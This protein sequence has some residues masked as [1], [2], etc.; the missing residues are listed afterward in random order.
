M[1]WSRVANER[2]NVLLFTI[3][4][5]VLM[6][7]MGGIAVDLAYYGV[8]D[9]EL[10][11]ATDAAALAGAGKLGFGDTVFPTV[12]TFAQ[13]YAAQN[14]W[15]D[16][17]NGP[18][19]VNLALN[20]ANDPAGNIVLG[21]WNPTATPKFTPSLDGT[22]VNAVLCRTTPVPVATTFFRLIGIT[23]M[24]AFAESIAVASPPA[25]PPPTTCLFPM[26]LSSCFFGGATSAGC[27]ATM[28]FISSSSES[29]V[30]VNSG[31]WL[32]LNPGE[33]PSANQVQGGITNAYNGVNCNPAISVG[34]E[35]NVSN[36]MAQST[37]SGTGSYPGLMS[38]FASKYHASETLTVNK[39]D[40]SPAYTGQGWEVF[41]P[42]IDTGGQ[43]PPGAITGTRTVAGFTRFVITQVSDRG[44][45][46][47]ANH[48]AGN[49]WDANCDTAHNGTAASV[50]PPLNAYRGIYGYYD[51]TY[52]QAPPAPAP[53]PVT[54]LAQMLRLVQ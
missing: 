24:A 20:T 4:L 25:T 42:V 7:V 15:R 54:A 34:T 18:T 44:E 45:C 8:V 27:G 52:W 23:S 39:S 35:L 37:Y 13:N 19:P 29:S 26:G 32:N 40:G 5:L 9:N 53:A 48:Y 10:Q 12:R 1:I 43:C 51:C 50:P 16:V 31:A 49:P 17:A 14:P 6:L 11:R 47:V 36:G 33:P 41:V 38:Y 46:A 3:G 30:G 21:V 22:Q 28:T 2:G